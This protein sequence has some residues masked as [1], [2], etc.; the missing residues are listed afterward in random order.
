MKTAAVPYRFTVD[1]Y[2]RMGDAGVFHE[3]AHVELLDGEIYQRTAAV[4]YRFTVDQY[5]RMGEAGVLRE[6]TRVELLDGEIYQ[7]APIGPRHA[8]VVDRL[9]ELLVTRLAGRA[10]VRVQ[11]PVPSGST[12]A[13]EPDFALLRRARDFYAEKRPRSEDVLLVIE[14]AD[15]PLAHDRAKLRIYAGA[16]IPE[17][18]IVDLTTDRIEVHRSPG[19]AGYRETRTA[20]RQQTLAPHAFADVSLAVDDILG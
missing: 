12:S 14:V 10:I 19:E 3:D 17:V 15:T 6:D 8:S 5:H 11:G 13:P 18:W 1:E 7:M 9:T 16:G 20:G 4:P 2:H